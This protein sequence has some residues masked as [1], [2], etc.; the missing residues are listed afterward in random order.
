MNRWL[1]VVVLVLLV[2]S[3]AMGLKALTTP[4]ATLAISGG[5]LPPGFISGGPLPPGFI[6]GGPLPPGFISGG[7]LPPG[8]TSTVAGH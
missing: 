5:P 8:L 2:L 6:S 1:M 7:P 3:S 4:Q